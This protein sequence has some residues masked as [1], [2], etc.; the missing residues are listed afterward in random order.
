MAKLINA[1][2]L[3][4]R[5][6]SK[7]PIGD[8]GKITIDECIAEISYAE[9]VEPERPRGKWID[10]ICDKCGYDGGVEAISGKANYCPKCGAD[11]RGE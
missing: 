4:K 1:D 11:M 5:L 9:P 8:I 7:K 2:E 3:I 6:R 10:G